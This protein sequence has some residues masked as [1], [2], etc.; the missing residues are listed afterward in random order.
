MNTTTASSSDARR[1]DQLA[2]RRARA[3][4]GW[5]THTAVYLAVNAGL[6]VLSL[7]NGG[8]WAVYPLLGWGLGLLIHG[9]A[10]WVLAPGNSIMARMVERERAR[11]QAGN[12]P[13]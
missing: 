6:I 11:L 1:L 12:D 3:K 13:W 7:A 5:F 8:G 2:H 4:M 10:V 9:L